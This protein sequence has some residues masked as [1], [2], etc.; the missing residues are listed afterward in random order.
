M[1]WIE[2][3]IALMLRELH[4]S[5]RTVGCLEPLIHVEEGED[6]IVVSAD[7]PCVMKEDI[8][9]FCTERSVEIQAKMSRQ[10]K[11]EKWGTVQREIAFNSFRRSIA[12]PA[13]VIPEKAKASFRNGL[14][15]M[16]LPKNIT[17]TR[18]EIE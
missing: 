15:T 5:W 13:E 17:K 1:G 8:Q 4:P 18:I 2:D 9:L 16:K 7:L 14:L 6:E 3:E 12:L 10:V 11:F